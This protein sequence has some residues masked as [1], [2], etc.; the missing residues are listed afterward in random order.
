MTGADA[1]RHG[2]TVNGH[3]VSFAAA[4]DGIA[5]WMDRTEAIL[6]KRGEIKER[7][8][9]KVQA[10]LRR[11]ARV[12]REDPTLDALMVDAMLHGPDRDPDP[13]LD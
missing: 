4:L 10:D 2:Q 5:A 11:A 7:S 9:G 3:P 8:N 13:G 6:V 12:L 1:A